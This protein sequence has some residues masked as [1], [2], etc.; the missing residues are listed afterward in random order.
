MYQSVG[1]CTSRRL[2]NVCSQIYMA[3]S[4]PELRGP[5]LWGTNLAYHLTSSNTA[6][7][8]AT[9][10]HGAVVTPTPPGLGTGLFRQ[11]QSMGHDHGEGSPHHEA[12]RKLRVLC[13]KAVHAFASPIVQS[14]HQEFFCDIRVLTNETLFPGIASRGQPLFSVQSR[15]SIVS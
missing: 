14:L 11:S 13:F 6:Y 7:L 1:D 15:L 2:T 12:L 3:L 9:C 10:C 8:I 4:S 5:Y